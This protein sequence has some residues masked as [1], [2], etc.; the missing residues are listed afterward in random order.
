MWVPNKPSAAIE[1]N[2]CRIFGTV[3]TVL[4]GLNFPRSFG[5][6]FL[7]LHR[8]SSEPVMAVVVSIINSNEQSTT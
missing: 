1:P 4:D 2:K 3:T 8:L 6:P 7:R 5:L